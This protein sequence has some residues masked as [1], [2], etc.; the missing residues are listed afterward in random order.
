[1]DEY[2]P[3]EVEKDGFHCPHCQVYSRQ[4]W[5]SI[6][7]YLGI[8][9]GQNQIVEGNIGYCERCSNYTLWVGEQMVYPS[10]SSA[11]KPSEDMP[12]EVKQ[13]FNEA[14][15]I[16]GDS[17][18]AA[19]ALL[20]LAMEKLTQKLTGNTDQ[21]LYHNIGEL[22]EKGEI[23]ERV[24]QA[25]DAVRITG[26]DYVHAGEIYSSDDRDTALRL[27]E[28]VNIIVQLTITREKLIEEAYSEIPENKKDSIE[29]RD[30]Q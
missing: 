7:S 2:T 1:M 26:N 30:S 16:V 18:K 27:F 17:P 6:K 13:D 4:R 25:L 24:Q 28:L 29:Q 3:P 8:S 10:T 22:V 5:Q 21:N 19:A 15:Q 9:S 11:P 14:R 23:D 12:E 20:R